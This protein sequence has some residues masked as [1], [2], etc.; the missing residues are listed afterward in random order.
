MFS[1]DKHVSSYVGLFRSGDNHPP[2][3]L[4]KK[5]LSPSS[6]R[7]Y[8]HIFV[9]GIGPNPRRRTNVMP[10]IYFCLTVLHAQ[11]LINREMVDRLEQIWKALHPS[12]AAPE[13]GEMGCETDVYVAGDGDTFPDP[14]LPPGARGGSSLSQGRRTEELTRSPTTATTDHHRPLVG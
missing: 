6:H 14:A 12:A 2:P 9:I 8:A 7:R 4:K 11:L 10:S 13:T 5:C 3:P 1:R